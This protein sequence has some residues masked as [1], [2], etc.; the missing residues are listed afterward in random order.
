MSGRS[1]VASILGVL[2]LIGGVVAGILLVRERQDLR[3]KAAVPGGQARVSLFPTTG[4]FK[5]GD[6]LPV[7]IYFNTSDVSISSINVRLRYPFSG[8]TPEI[9]ASNVTIN[10]VLASS[11]KWSCSKKSITADG[12]NVLIDIGCSIE[13]ATGYKTNSD[14]LLAT[15]DLKVD[16]IPSTNPFKIT[17][18]PAQSIVTQLSNGQDILN[19]P[20]QNV[21]GGNY[22][23]SAGSDDQTN[24]TVTPTKQPTATPTKVPTN[25][26]TTTVRPTGTITPTVTVKPTSS[27]VTPTTAVNLPDA[28]FGAPT[29]M[30][31]GLGVVFILSAVLLAL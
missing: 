6:T 15:F 7:S 26:P 22:T 25:T 5:V 31:L 8:T 1:V 21:G 23:I 13:S 28:G 12:G 30:G 9:S 18:D 2:V 27:A 19:I 3:E 11:G 24:P 20:D 17:F 14:T 4:N 29:L 16:R 10:S